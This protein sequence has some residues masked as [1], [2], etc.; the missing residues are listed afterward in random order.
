M[1]DVL[2]TL[3]DD[4]LPLRALDR[5]LARFL[6]GL[7]P[8]A[9]PTLLLAAA[10]LAHREGQGHSCLPLAE[11]FDPGLPWQAEGLLP[12]VQAITAGGD[13]AA[14]QASWSASPLLQGECS[15]L[16]LQG[17]RLYLR[18]YAQC[19]AR[20]AAQVL[21]RVAPA[22]GER[23]DAATETVTDTAAREWLD[24]LFPPRTDGSVDG[25]R[26]ACALA[27][28]GRLTVITGGPGTGK[29][30]TA[31][32]LLVLLQALHGGGQPLRVALAA[33]TGKAAARLRQSIAQALQGLKP[34]LGDSALLD[35][36]QRQAATARTLHRLL[37]ARP[38]TRHLQHDADHPLD[39]DL[40]IVDEASMVH[41]EMMA[42]LLQALPASA[43]VVLL[44][45]KDQ[46]ASVE[47]GAVLGDLCEDTPGGTGR[48]TALLSDS[49]RFQGRIGDL[50]RAV[51]A[52]RP[53]QALALLQPGDAE[54]A[55]L[56]AA[57]PAA[58]LQLALHGRGAAPGYVQALAA[59]AQRPADDAGADTFHAWVLR[60][61]RGFDDFRVL[62]ALREG[63]FGVAGL[64]AAIEQAL[65]DRGVLRR[66]GGE[67]LEGRALMVT[68]N[69]PD[70]GLSN[71]DVGLV[72][73][74]PG[75][76][77]SLR[78]WFADGDDLR[79]VAVTR[80]AAVETAWAMTV[81]KSQGSEFRH[82]ALVLP[83]QPTPVLTRELVYTGITRARV[84]CTVAGAR[85]G[86][87]ADAVQQ[88]TRRS[89]GLRQRLEEQ[90]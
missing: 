90:G 39:L 13:I 33:P 45:D 38:G 12:L 41:L 44:G 77:G 10:L 53:A 71:G 75:E 49:R 20:V 56:P 84:H 86:V 42:A 50:A 69:D 36:L 25:Q 72:L 54:A 40:L 68:R 8:Q 66:R 29:T 15:P 11:L 67:W 5:A 31:A 37:G 24:R 32:R 88:R 16:Q 19:E 89:S 4:T 59:L 79:S 7:D 73:R 28:R 80:L 62:C 47:A 27:L 52:G 58:L 1:S 9:P 2:Q 21:Q 3:D 48:Y 43:R 51:N 14:L 46:L 30:Y 55:W 81:H 23:I 57:D 61:L 64:N 87:L 85:P 34:Q 26:A 35:E 63:P 18:R 74:A 70:L 82:V 22:G 78:A 6:H 60:V 17:A 76:G 65:L 83:D